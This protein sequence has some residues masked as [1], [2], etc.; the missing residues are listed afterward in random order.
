[1]EFP[2]EEKVIKQIKNQSGITLIALIITI[3]V[4][5][6]LSFTISSNLN[7]GN[8]LKLFNDF[9]NDMDVLE[10]RVSLYVSENGELPV[11]GAKYTDIS[12]IGNRSKND[13]ENYYVIDLDLLDN[14]TLTNG[15]GYFEYKANSVNTRDVYIIN[16][17]SYTIYYPKGITLEEGKTIYSLYE[18]DD[19]KLKPVCKIT[20]DLT[21][22]ELQ[23]KIIY[24]LEFSD[25]VT[26]FTING[27]TLENGTKGTFKEIETGKKYTL[28]ATIQEDKNTQ[29]IIVNKDTCVL[30]SD[31]S[32]K[33]VRSA[34]TVVTSKF[35]ISMEESSNLGNTISYVKVKVQDYIN[36]LKQ[37]T[38]P[39]GEIVN[40]EGE[41]FRNFI[42]PATAN[43]PITIKVQNMKGQE[44]EKTIT[45]KNVEEIVKNGLILWYDGINNTGNQHDNNATVWKDLSGNGN[46][47]ILKG[48]TVWTDNG[49][50]FN[51]NNNSWVSIGELNYDTITLEVVVKNSAINTFETIYICNYEDGG[52][53]LSYVDGKNFMQIRGITN[54]YKKVFSN[55]NVE[56]NKMYYLSGDYDQNVLRIFENGVETQYIIPDK[57]KTPANNTILALGTNPYGTNGSGGLKGIIYS[58]RVYNRILT[59]GERNINYKVDKANYNF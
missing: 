10:E 27:I 36:G 9:K 22:V 56:V 48:G 18:T 57:I 41:T 7:T 38:M 4:I 53:G 26:G 58:V 19:I 51:G 45:I 44:I 2:K 47:G 29:T 24:T 50:V 37:I 21:N 16:E 31:T 46:D 59:Q 30:D 8:K 25:K 28:E 52:Y 42:Y 12:H 3:I 55:S 32:L 35:A 40:C 54:G 43:G 15:R 13:N 20:A 23:N 1:M 14:L 39:N 5:L 34:K 11:I 6:I 49:L 33:N 17:Q